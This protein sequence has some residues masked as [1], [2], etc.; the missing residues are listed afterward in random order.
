MSSKAANFKDLGTDKGLATLNAHL[1]DKSYIEG[2]KAS[3]ADFNVFGQ[4]NVNAVDAAKFPHVVRWHTHINSYTPFNKKGSMA[5]SSKDKKTKAASKSPALAPKSPGQ[6]PKSPALAPKSPALA[7]KSPALAPK[8]PGQAPKSPAKNNSKSQE[9]DDEVDPFMEKAE[10]KEK[11]LF[12]V[13]EDDDEAY[14]RIAQIAKDK[15]EKD[16]KAGKTKAVAKSSLIIDVKPLGSD[17]DM[18]QMEKEVRAIKME[19]LT[20]AGSELIKIAFGLNKLRIIC[21]F[22][23][24]LISSTDEITEAI[25]ALTEHVQST[26]VYAFNKV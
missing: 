16:K 8:S 1:A 21:V 15:K 23:D 24:D 19:G 3:S 22:I 4:V 25:E 10:E 17:T 26:D 14:K 20:W 13:T 9:D 11:D 18:A 7:P 2:Y 5:D 6:A 12:E